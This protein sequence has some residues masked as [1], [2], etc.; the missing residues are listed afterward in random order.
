MNATPPHP[1]IRLWNYG[2]HYRSRAMLATFFTVANKIADLAPEAL[3]GIAVDIVVRREDS[4]LARIGIEDVSTQ[5]TVLGIVTFIVWFLESLFEYLLNISWRDLAQ[6]IQHDLRLDAYGHIQKLDLAYFEDRSTGG[7]MSIL[8]DDVNQLELFLNIGA[9]EIIRLATTMLVLGVAFFALAPSVAWLAAIPM[10]I[11]IWGSMRYQKRLE[12]RYAAVRN[13]VGLLN[14]FLANNLGGMATIKSFTAEDYEVERIGRESNLYR[15]INHKAIVMSSAFVPLIRMAIVM[16]FIA[17]LVAGGQAALNGTLAVGAY[18]LMVYMTQRLLWPLTRLGETLDLYQR[19]MAST[20]RIMDLLYT[21]PTIT[22]GTHTIAKVQGEVK[23]EQVRFAYQ[24]RET[25]LHGLDMHVPAGQTAAIVGATGAG[26]S[27]IVKLLLRFYDVTDG[28]I[29]LDGQDIRTLKLK[30]LRDAIGFVSQDVFLFHG[31]VKENIAY[32]TFN[33]TMEQIIEAAKI[34]EAHDFIMSLPDGYDTIV[35]ERGQKLSGGQ[36][37]RISIARAIVKN[38]PILVLDEA[39][40]AVD[41]ETEAAIQRSLEKI[42]V[43]RTMILIAHRLS[44]IRHADQIFVIENGQ[45]IERGHHD[46]LLAHNNLYAALWRVQTGEKQRGM[47][48][49]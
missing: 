45:M 35:G 25:V 11:I 15:Q 2:S 32:G 38:P 39:T 44:T 34:A 18:S 9:A 27:T 4:L 36:R 5:L 47:A 37:Q 48:A 13:Q 7:L 41:N 28:R 10:P 1:L 31:T 49:D 22:D 16:G 14:G 33:A 21:T 23:F 12:P 20:R 19:G 30:D 43:G 40:A 17:I 26:K 29:T 3:I 8:N 6:S 42:A 46:E 24:G